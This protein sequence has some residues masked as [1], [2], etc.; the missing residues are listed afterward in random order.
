MLSCIVPCYVRCD[1]VNLCP[2]VATY[3]GCTL[4]TGVSYVTAVADVRDTCSNIIET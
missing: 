2:H 3:V 1:H 4:N